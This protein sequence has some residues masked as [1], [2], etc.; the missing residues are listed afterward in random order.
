MR[1]EPEILASEIASFVVYEGGW[2]V[3]LGASLR[4]HLAGHAG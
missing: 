1:D 4:A 3:D 2:Q